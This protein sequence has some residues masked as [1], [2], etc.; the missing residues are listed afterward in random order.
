VSA[1]TG[2]AGQ[3]TEK[4][5][6][7]EHKGHV[8]L[9]FDKPVEWVALQPEITRNLAEHMARTAYKLAFGDDP[10]PQGRSIITDA[11][12]LK[13]VNRVKLMLRTL[14]G[15]PE[16]VRAEQVVDTCLKEVA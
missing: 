8:V 14:D 10:T 12:R 3:G 13:L 7:S 15:K 16:Q 5:V 6:V 1:I 9:H 11:T 2:L 4:I